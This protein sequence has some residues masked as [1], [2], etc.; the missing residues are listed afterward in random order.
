MCGIG[1]IWCQILNRLRS[2][3]SGRFATSAAA[4]AVERTE[5]SEDREEIQTRRR[6]LLEVAEF[7]ADTIARAY[8]AGVDAGKKEA[9]SNS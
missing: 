9:G 7:L 2:Q 5:N 6:D 4:L 1:N 3:G 8:L